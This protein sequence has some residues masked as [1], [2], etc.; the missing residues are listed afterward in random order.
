[1]HLQLRQHKA[2]NAAAS[3]KTNATITFTSLAAK[4]ITKYESPYCV[5]QETLGEAEGS[6]LAG[7]TNPATTAPTMV[8]RN[9]N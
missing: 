6:A 1:M 3:T 9:G 5:V 2:K 7:S 8:R 4:L